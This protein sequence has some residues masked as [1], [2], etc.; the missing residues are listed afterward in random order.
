MIDRRR[1]RSRPNPNSPLGNPSPGNPSLGNPFQANSSLANSP[2]SVPLPRSRR[3]RSGRRLQ[4]CRS[5]RQALQRVGRLGIGLSGRHRL[6]P[7]PSRR[8][9]AAAT[10][11]PAPLTLRQTGLT[12][13]TICDL[14]LKQLYLQGNLLGI[15]FARQMRLPFTVVEEGL[16]FLKDDKCIEVTSGDLVGPVSY[17]FNLTDLGRKRAG[18]RSRCAATSGRLRSPSM[19]RAA[20]PPANRHGNGVQRRGAQAGLRQSRDS[21]RGA[22]GPG[23]GGLQRQVDLRLRTA[24]QRQ[25]DDRQGPRQLS[26]P[27]GGDI[28]VPY[29]IYAENSIITVFDPTIHRTTDDADVLDQIASENETGSITDPFF[30]PPFDLHWHRVRRP[31]VITAGELTLDMLDLHTTRPATFIRLAAYQGEL[32]GCF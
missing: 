11:P 21:R 1:R 15:Q 24:G 7:R 8:D 16:W 13:G 32:R 22:A 31:V 5:V 28:Y 19:P 9:A 10:A 6:A 4:R 14:I 29:A 2:L 17:R 30:S 3:R 27:Y 12:L 20:M 23:T 26:Q 25:N 18:K